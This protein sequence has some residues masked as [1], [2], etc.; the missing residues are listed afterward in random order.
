[1]PLAVEAV[2]ASLSS[3]S[4]GHRIIYLPVVTSTMD[5]AREEAERGVEEGVVVV[6]EEQTAGR[7]RFG[8]R[9]LSVPGQNLYLSVLLYP[10]RESCARL[11]VMAPVAVR[12]A[13]HQV[14]GLSPTLKWPNDVRLRDRKV[15]GILVE[16][17]VQG[18]EVRHAI[19]G[20]GINVNF[21]AEQYAE[22]APG[23]TSLAMELGKPVS[24]EDLLQ[25]VLAELGLI[26]TYLKGWE[27]A[28]EEWQL[29]LETLGREIKVQWG[30]QV[31]EGVAE[32]VDSE[33]NLLLRRGDGTLVTLTAGEVTLQV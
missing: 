3:A 2:Q 13:I 32:A 21:N 12:R 29:S 20:I 9:W 28:W 24:R 25:A 18:A 5:I 4:I 33:G 17:A 19:V 22:D 15:S 7:G 11:G 31:E 14:S 16:T 26:Y 6:A 8:R 30:E 1:M 10:S 27:E 23:A